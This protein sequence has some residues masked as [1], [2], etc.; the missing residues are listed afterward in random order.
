VFRE[1]GAVR[2]HVAADDR[3][4]ALETAAALADRRVGGVTGVPVSVWPSSSVDDVVVVDLGSRH[5]PPA[6]AQSRAAQVAAAGPLA[7][8]IDSTLRGN[9]AEELLARHTTLGRA[10]LVVP[11]FP[12]LGRVCREGVVE[13]D[14]LPVH[15]GSAGADVRRPVRSSRPA[16]HLADAGAGAIREL[17]TLDAVVDWLAAPFGFAVADATDD[18]QLRSIVCAWSGNEDVLLAGTSAAIGAAAGPRVAVLAGSMPA[19]VLVICGSASDT[20]RRQVAAAVGRGAVQAGDERAA[21]DALRSGRHAILVSP[22]PSGE[23]SPADADAFARALTA[24][25]RRVTESVHELGA[26]VVL[27]GD[28]ASALLGE[29]Q[30]HVLGSLTPGT[31]WVDSPDVR[32]PVITRAGAFGRDGALADLMWGTLR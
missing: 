2:L 3:T 15:Q 27:G 20:A 13:A 16:D 11:A 18:E 9:W 19:P 4:G 22:I 17:R 5:L 23:V 7:H 8:K 12:A 21:A 28:T 6:E 1:N 24:A 30:V 26:L 14:G 31:A 29:S 10:V 25:A 32:C